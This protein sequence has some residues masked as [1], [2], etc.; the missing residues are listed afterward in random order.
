MNENNSRPRKY[1]S[2]SILGGVKQYGFFPGTGIR[3]MKIVDVIQP[4]F[5]SPRKKLPPFLISADMRSQR[6]ITPFSAFFVTWMVSVPAPS[7]G[8]GSYS[9]C[10]PKSS[11][12][13]VSPQVSWRY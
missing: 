3:N 7:A 12:L 1:P 10:W 11:N 13:P 5:W 8:T 4:P 9:H 2:C 6:K